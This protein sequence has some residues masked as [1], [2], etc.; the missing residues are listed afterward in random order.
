MR[1]PGLLHRDTVQIVHVT[2]GAPNSRGV[3]TETTET[4]T[5]SGVNVQ[6]TDTTET[7]DGQD[8]VVTRHR[9]A[10][11]TPA[12]IPTAL[13]RITWDGRTFTIVGKPKTHTSRDAVPHT[14]VTMQEATG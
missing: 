3:P 13:D 7:V 8:T 9:V 14:E 1:L 10:G 12:R 4:T 11:P 2:Q 6:Q 5:W